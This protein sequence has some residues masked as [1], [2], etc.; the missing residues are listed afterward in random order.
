MLGSKLQEAK[1]HG[2]AVY[3]KNETSL[4]NEDKNDQAKASFTCASLS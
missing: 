4:E 1:L 3:F 2:M